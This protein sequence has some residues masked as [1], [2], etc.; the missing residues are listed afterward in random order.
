MSFDRLVLHSNFL[1]FLAHILVTIDKFTKL[2]DDTNQAI[3]KDAHEIV[4]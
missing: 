2:N 3:G 1:S 4:L